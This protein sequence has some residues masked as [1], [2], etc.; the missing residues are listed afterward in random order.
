MDIA[1]YPYLFSDERRKKKERRYA[2]LLDLWQK[3][4]ISMIPKWFIKQIRDISEIFDVD[5]VGEILPFEPMDVPTL[6]T[7]ENIPYYQCLPPEIWHM[8]IIHE[9]IRLI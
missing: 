8:Y 2:Y 4:E 7:A 3:G 5:L 1:K 6:L 9:M